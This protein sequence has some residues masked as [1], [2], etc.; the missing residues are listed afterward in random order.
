M[1]EQID[2]IKNWK[3]SLNENTLHDIKYIGYHCSNNPNLD[4]NVECVN[5]GENDYYEWHEKIL[6]SIKIKYQEAE[7]YIK[8]SDGGDIGFHGDDTTKI[9][10]FLNKIGV[11]GVFVDEDKPNKRWGKYCYKVYLK[12]VEF[13]RIHDFIMAEEGDEFCFLYLYQNSKPIFKKITEIFENN[14]TQID[15]LSWKDIT[16]TFNGHNG[17]FSNYRVEIPI[18]GYNHKQ[19]DL[20]I[21]EG[22]FNQVHI[23]LSEKLR[24]NNLT[25]EIYK[26]TA[27]SLGHIFSAKDR[28]INPIIDKI[29]T[30]LKNDTDFDVYETDLGHIC[31]SKE[32]DPKEKE[33]LLKNFYKITNI[34]NK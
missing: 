34:H 7:D 6:E 18:E 15:V 19:V 20:N 30:K 12:N 16:I 32:I 14:L 11:C 5:L 29:W 27:N 33:N 28:R 9:S 24:G 17:M 10:N 25:Y 1:R 13:E 26:A 8:L 22:I 23:G 2:K 4:K 31:I 3:Q 21:K